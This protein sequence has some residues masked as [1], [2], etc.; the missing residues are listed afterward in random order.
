[1]AQMMTQKQ[2]LDWIDE[3]SFAITELTLY[4]DTHPSD[5]KALSCFEQYNKE[6]QKALSLYSEQYGPLTLD[7]IRNNNRWYWIMQPWPWEG[8]C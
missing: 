8:V 3:V 5:A 2:L 6:R 7:G 4:L 1:M